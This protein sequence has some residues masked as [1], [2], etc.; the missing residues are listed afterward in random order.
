MKN[1]DHVTQKNE[2]Y[3]P[4]FDEMRYIFYQSCMIDRTNESEKDIEADGED[5]YGNEYIRKAIGCL[6]TDEK[7]RLC[8]NFCRIRNTF[9]IFP[10]GREPYKKE[11]I[12]QLLKDMFCNEAESDRGFDKMWF[13]VFTEALHPNNMI[14]TVS[15]RFI[16]SDKYISIQIDHPD[17]RH[18]FLVEK[19][20]ILGYEDLMEPEKPE[21]IP[22]E[23]EENE[24]TC[25]DNDCGSCENRFWCNSA[26][27]M[28][29][30]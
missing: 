10:I 23:E 17:N 19:N 21:E 14:V 3:I 9:Y 11:E 2:E 1:H 4:E 24:C 22:P 7:G 25:C 30:I 18:P 16:G 28:D 12:D 8:I 13:K 5:C 26:E 29:E 20:Y 6:Y 27:D 15:T